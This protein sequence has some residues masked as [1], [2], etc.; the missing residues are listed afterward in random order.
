[1]IQT[2]HRR[3]VP[4]LAILMLALTLGLGAFI[5]GFNRVEAAQL[6][7][8]SLQLSSSIINATNTN[9]VFSFTLATAGTLGSIVLELCT[10]DPFPETPCTAP[11]GLDMTGALLASQSGVVGFSIDPSS[12]ANKLVLSRVPAATVVVPASYTF[13]DIT[14]PSVIGTLYGRFVTYATNDASGPATDKAGIAWTTNNQFTLNTEVPQFLQFC[15]GVTI[16]AFDCSTAAGSSIDFGNL[17]SGAV[18]AATSQFVSVGNAGFG[19]NV[20]AYGLTMT[21]GT[22][23]IP[24]LAAPTFSG[25]GNSQFGFNLRANSQ[26]GIGSN[27]IGP[28]AASTTANYDIPDR[29]LFNSGDTIVVSSGSSDYR[30]FTVSYITNVNTS[31]PAGRYTTTITY[32]CLA[33]F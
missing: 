28:G 32:V 8:R 11:A 3:L 23:T 17:S 13:T 22:N 20:G 14:N 15:V 21:S 33:N 10:N 6:E 19:F 26:P 24:S 29:F 31:Q 16:S 25:P 12:T 27:P 30:K 9:Y 4:K 1:M 7:L 5:S 18:A 2:A